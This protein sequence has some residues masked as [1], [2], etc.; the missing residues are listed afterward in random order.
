MK[1]FLAALLAVFA[2]HALTPGGLSTAAQAQIVAGQP[3]AAV[4]RKTDVYPGAAA[5][6]DFASVAKR[7][8]FFKANGVIA[9]TFS[10]LPGLTVTRASGG[11]AEDQTGA[12]VWFNSGQARITNKGLL[13]EESRTNLLLYSQQFDNAAWGKSDTT[14]TADQAQAPDGTTTADLLTEGSA[15]TAQVNQAV[16]ITAGQTLSV[17]RYFKR[18]NSDWV[19]IKIDSTGGANG[20]GQWFNL[21]TG[22]KGNQYSF[23]TG[24]FVSATVT[25]ASNGFYRCVV[26][27]T[28][29]AAAT[30]A[31]VRTF[32]TS[33]NNTE[34]RVNGATRYEWQADL[35]VGSFITS[36]IPTT[37]ATVTR[38]ADDIFL[39]ASG[40]AAGDITTLFQGYFPVQNPTSTLRTGGLGSA[41]GN[42][43]ER[44]NWAVVN[45]DGTYSASSVTAAAVNQSITGLTPLMRAGQRLK[46][47]MRRSGTTWSAAIDGIYN[48]GSNFTNGLPAIEGIRLGRDAGSNPIYWNGYIETVLAYP[49]ALSDGSF[50]ALS[51]G[52]DPSSLRLDFAAGSYKNAAGYVRTNYLYPTENPTS[53]ATSSTANGVTVTQ[54]GTGVE[55]G[56]AYSDYRWQGTSTGTASDIKLGSTPA[57]SPSQ[58]WAAAY[59]AKIMA[60]ALP[61]GG[62]LKVAL[63]E[64]TGAGGY[65]SETTPAWYPTLSNSAITRSFSTRTLMGTAGKVQLSAVLGFSNGVAVDVTIRVYAPQLEQTNYPTSFI[66]T[67][68][69]AASVTTYT[70]TNPADVGNLTFTRASTAY[71][72][73]AAGNLI[74][75]A[76]NVPRITNAGLLIEESR[77]NLFPY[78]F[79]DTPAQI[80]TTLSNA[81]I[82]TGSLTPRAAG[83]TVTRLTST[84]SAGRI[85]RNFTVAN[86]ALA[87]TF[88]VDVEKKATTYAV[89]AGLVGGTGVSTTLIF[90]GGTGEISSGVGIVEDRGAWW[91]VSVT[92]TNN[93]T[94]NTTFYTYVQASVG[95]GGTADIALP[96]LQVGA[97]A[98]SYVPSRANASA[99]RVVDVFGYTGLPTAS[100]GTYAVKYVPGAFGAARRLISG[101]SGGN[102]VT[103]LLLNTVA[104]DGKVAAFD[105]T[106]L[107][108]TS[109]A[110]SLNTMSS[111]AMRYDGTNVSVSN[112][113]G[114]ISTAAGG[115]DFP[116]QTS[117]YFGGSPSGSSSDIL[118]GLIVQAARYPFAAN[119]NELVYRSAANF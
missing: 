95:V 44:A 67:T 77:T 70:S 106:Q 4:L 55:A 60:G 13:V 63:I 80:W 54:V 74:L 83:A 32:N 48:A 33:G 14:V 24:A 111:A 114:A 21:S 42:N 107:A 22:A 16:T 7:G 8:Q 88:A 10:G 78:S 1:R 104:A 112:L 115:A 37:S 92:A 28:V 76:A 62:A 3:A 86:D 73:D 72:T 19:L 97:F 93:S 101:P 105:S 6:L 64:L 31:A 99:T 113:G 56:M 20:F 66:P 91:R 5:A 58:T 18:G 49:T 15:G 36:P 87:R 82:S 118:N 9:P 65:V 100:A 39:T 30:T 69:A 17:S 52:V 90:N 116:T 71:G 41:A 84:A 81:T 29:D 45:S 11:Y 108:L 117:L 57:A 26:T 2:I 51:S 27:G 43:A 75:F 102:F 59:S 23:G 110:A 94:G 50:Q 53:W 96:D 103:P 109:T 46:L 25:Q 35:Q 40:L 79:D 38:A 119:D 98:T 68:V 12:L 47:A 85:Q 34:T 89:S 61:S